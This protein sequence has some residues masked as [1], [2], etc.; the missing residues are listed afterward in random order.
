MLNILKQ[1]CNIRKVSEDSGINGSSHMSANA[2]SSTGGSSCNS[3][4]VQL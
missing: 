2:K 3:S 1:I 4:S